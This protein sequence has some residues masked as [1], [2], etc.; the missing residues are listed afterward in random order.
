MFESKPGG[1]EDLP[2][3]ILRRKSNKNQIDELDARD[4]FIDLFPRD[5]KSAVGMLKKKNKISNA[6]LAALWNMD[7]S[8]FA[9]ALDDPRRYRNEDFLT[10]LCLCFKLPDWISELLFKR[11]RFQLDDTDKRHRAIKNI[12]RVQS[13]EG[14]E[15]ANEYLKKMHLDQLSFVI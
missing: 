8:T 15:A 14:I 3:G 4:V 13:N 1:E 2:Q 6:K 10:I 12:L 11:A 7:D 5:F 9:R